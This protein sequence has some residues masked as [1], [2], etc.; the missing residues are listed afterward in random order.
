MAVHWVVFLK[1]HIKV[2]LS[3]EIML[4]CFLEAKSL[5]MFI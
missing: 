2:A 4:S 3:W 5:V 1:V